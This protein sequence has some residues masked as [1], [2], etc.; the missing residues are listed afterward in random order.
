MNFVTEAIVNIWGKCIAYMSMH[1]FL[2]WGI[3]TMA[4]GIFSYFFRAEVSTRSSII[5]IA[6]GYFALTYA[7]QRKR[8][9]AKQ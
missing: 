8:E 1:S 3:G 6:V 2:I 4:L 5:Q 7:L 9:K